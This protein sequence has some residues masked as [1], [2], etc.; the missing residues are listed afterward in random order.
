MLASLTDASLVD[1]DLLYEPKYDGIRAIAEIG[2][3]VRLWSRLGNDKTGQFP[4]I[5]KALQQWAQG[6]D[7][8]VILDGEIVALDGQGEP[9][10]FQ[11]L[12]GRQKAGREGPSSVA[13][14]A[15]DLLREGRTDL[16]DR[17]LTE[18]RAALERLFG[19][20][21]SRAGRSSVLRISESVRGD[22]RSLYRRALDS[23]WEGLIAK[24][25]AS[26]YQSGKRT[27]DWRKL[28][29]V[30]EQEFVVGGWTEPRQ[31]R[32]YFGALLLGVHEDASRGGRKGRAGS[33]AGP[34]VYVGHT[35]T[36]FTEAELTRV[37]KRLRPLETTTC[38]FREQPRKTNE[39]PHWVDPK[40]VAQVKFTEWTA[41]GKLRHPVYLGLRDDKRPEDV[42][43]ERVSRL[44]A[45]SEDRL[46]PGSV[47]GPRY[48]EAM[49]KLVDR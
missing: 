37:M 25:A 27:P 34:L 28:K 49:N 19:R 22:G 7:V 44:H 3:T 8:P 1:P 32:A 16:R 15:F 10:G 41:D 38:P 6:V 9:A 35:G 4:E 40:L 5:V 43:R 21:P 17:P 36:G 29:I 42:H 18:R 23:G 47:S 39:R 45:A 11:Q 26:R 2:E 20:G 12:Q 31:T 30:H 24:H 13:F 48:G 14:I 33:A 46:A